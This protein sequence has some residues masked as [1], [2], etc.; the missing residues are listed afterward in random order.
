M[1]I[2]WA[3]GHQIFLL[4]FTKTW[5]LG[6]SLDG[7]TH[8]VNLKFSCNQFLE[9]IQAPSITFSNVLESNYLKIELEKNCPILDLIS[10]ILTISDPRKQ[11]AFFNV[12]VLPPLNS[13]MVCEEIRRSWI[14]YRW[15]LFFSTRAR[16]AGNI[17]VLC[18]RL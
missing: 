2:K 5:V 10:N 12:F 3:T 8:Q 16:L 6:S 18:K 4:L 17:L 15:H 14:C 7:W 11:F 1:K 9:I 13:V